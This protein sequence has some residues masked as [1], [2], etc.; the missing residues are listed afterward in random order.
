MTSLRLTPKH[1]KTVWTHFWLRNNLSCSSIGRLFVL[2]VI[3]S[4]VCKIS[5]VNNMLVWVKWE[6][7]RT[8][9]FMVVW[10]DCQILSHWACSNVTVKGR[11]RAVFNV[12]ESDP[13]VV[14]FRFWKNKDSPLLTDGHSLSQACYT[15][16]PYLKM[17]LSGR[18]NYLLL[19]PMFY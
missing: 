19:D 17:K 1:D 2:L 4:K 12:T 11:G 8:I 9:C 14:F 18:C 6:Q 15:C 7:L 10:R 16:Y 5:H 13:W 3:V